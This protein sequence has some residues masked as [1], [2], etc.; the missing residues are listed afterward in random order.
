MLRA[1][2]Q[3][4]CAARVTLVLYFSARRERPVACRAGCGGMSQFNEPVELNSAHIR[5]KNEF[6]PNRNRIF[7]L[8]F[9]TFC[10]FLGSGMIEV[11]GCVG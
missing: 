3:S 5:G 8:H 9:G 1:R 6:S 11:E 2:L 10:I 4:Y 7:P